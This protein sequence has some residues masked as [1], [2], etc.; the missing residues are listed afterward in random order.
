MRIKRILLLAL[1]AVLLVANGEHVYAAYSKDDT[2][3]NNNDILFYDPNYSNNLCSATGSDSPTSPSGATGID[4]LKPSPNLQAIFQGLINGG[5]NAVQAA[6]VMGNMYTESAHAFNPDVYESGKNIPSAGYGLVQWTNNRP[7]YTSGRR[8]NLFNFATQQGMPASSLDLQ[9]KFVLKEYNESYKSQLS[10]SAFSEGTNVADATRAW[11]E[12]YERP[13]LRGDDPAKINSERIPAAEKIYTFYSSL[14]PST[15]APDAT[16]GGCSETSASAGSG[17]IVTTA[18]SLAWPASKGI[19]DGDN[20][21][22]QAMPAYQTAKPK[23]APEG[24]PSDCGAFVATVMHMSGV[25]LDFPNY[26]VHVQAE[27]VKAHPEKYKIIEN[28]QLSDIQ[29]GD[30]LMLNNTDHIE[31]AQGGAV[32]IDA[33]NGSRIPSVRPAGAQWMISNGSFIARHIGVTE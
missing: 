27:Y 13:L 2:F 3:Y 23:Y 19:S 18:Q 31:I 10:S 28:A 9:V 5:M 16:S 30:I 8:T 14:A 22:S 25:D 15:T 11:M 1:C 17:D 12:I 24:L 32:G 6:A 33:S 4:S 20:Q 26:Q 7:D 21:M 29:P